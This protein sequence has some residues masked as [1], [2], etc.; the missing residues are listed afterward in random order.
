MDA[1]AGAQQAQQQ[2][3][4][5]QQ[6]E[7]QRQQVR[8]SIMSQMGP[9]AGAPQQPRMPMTPA[10]TLPPPL[11]QSMATPQVRGIPGVAIALDSLS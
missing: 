8:A 7:A 6:L 3:L 4:S 1:A 10:P 5:T 9:S 11:R 2:G